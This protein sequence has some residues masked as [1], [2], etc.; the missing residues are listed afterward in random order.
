MAPRVARVAVDVPL[1]H[2]DRLFDYEVPE[3]LAD[4]AVPG[5]RV[6]LEVDVLAKYV[7][8]LLAA[9]AAPTDS[10]REGA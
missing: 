4:A 5:A 3:P 1:A 7:E 9:P 8:H 2:L 10:A 6:N